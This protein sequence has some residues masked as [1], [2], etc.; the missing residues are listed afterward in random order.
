MLPAVWPREAISDDDQQQLLAEAD[1]SSGSIGPSEW[2]SQ[3]IGRSRRA[4]ERWCRMSR[5]SKDRYDLALALALGRSSVLA[6]D[7]A[8]GRARQPPTGRKA[9]PNTRRCTARHCTAL[10]L[11]AAEPTN[12]PSLN[13][14]LLTILHSNFELLRAASS[15][16]RRCYAVF[17][18]LFHQAG[19]GVWWISLWIRCMVWVTWE[20]G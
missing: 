15:L 20:S 19:S 13:V 17:L 18:E 3:R 4:D 8:C 16:L 5:G 10:L 2:C 9:E 6:T 1:E 12:A 7:G 11:H 14:L